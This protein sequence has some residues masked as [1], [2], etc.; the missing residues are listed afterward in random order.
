MVFVT[1][2]PPILL[3]EKP[4][5]LSGENQQSI[6]LTIISSFFTVNILK[7]FGVAQGNMIGSC[8]GRGGGKRNVTCFPIDLWAASSVICD[9]SFVF[10]FLVL[11]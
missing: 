4:T 1:L 9:T 3:E 5:I 8:P 11:A 10:S 2:I 6:I 7:R